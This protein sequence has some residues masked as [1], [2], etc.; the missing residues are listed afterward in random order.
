MYLKEK[1]EL[2]IE[3]G[4]VLTIQRYA[5]LEYLYESATHPTVE[6]IYQGLKKRFSTISEATIYNTLEL[7]K[8]HNL[9]REVTIEKGKS[10]FDY[11]TRPHHHFLCRRCGYIYDIDV[12]GCPL[13][14]KKMIDGHRI[15]EM[16]PYIVGIC[17]ECLKGEKAN[18]EM[19]K[20]KRVV[21][22]NIC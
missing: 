14:G 7:F 17:S 5:V 8:N 22:N 16:R 18:E 13:V 10:H 4:I 19:G 3:K 6:E 9:I 2:L 21:L 20:Q 12:E 11:E 15:E 1:I